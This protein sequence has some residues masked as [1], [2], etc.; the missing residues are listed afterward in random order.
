[1]S[2]CAQGKHAEAE[3]LFQRAR[4]VDPVA[5][6]QLIALRREGAVAAGPTP[7]HL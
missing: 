3:T 2:H 7:E 5:S 1:M 6:E 4:Q